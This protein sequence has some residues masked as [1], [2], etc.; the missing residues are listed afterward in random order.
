MWK[1]AALWVSL[2]CAGMT[3]QY[4]ANVSQ[5]RSGLEA[6]PWGML[7]GASAWCGAL[8]W[9]TR[10]T[11]QQRLTPEVEEALRQIARERSACRRCGTSRRPDGLFCGVCH[12]NWIRGI[13][14]CLGVLL[15]STVFFVLR[16]AGAL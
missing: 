12:P 13:V 8:Y 10:W 16:A 14:F 6:F 11:A 7:L 3:A 4:L 5:G 1:Q 15:C 2:L 9:F